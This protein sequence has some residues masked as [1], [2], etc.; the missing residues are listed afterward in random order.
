MR[1][2]LKGRKL[3]RTASHRRATLNA[4]ATAL[5]RHKKIK[6][7]LAKA[8]ET[9]VFVE[10]LITKA[11]QDTVVARRHVAR[12]IKEK[13]VLQ[14]LF[15]EVAPKVAERNG[16]YTRVVKLGRRLGD[17]AEMA[18]IE[19]VDY[20]D[21]GVKKQPKKKQ[22]EEP[23]AEAETVETVEA[24]EEEAAAAEDVKEAEV[25]EEETKAE[26]EEE[27]KEEAKAEETSEEKAEEKTEE[28]KAE[29]EEKKEEKK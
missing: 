22:K 19:L 6:T 1:H 8:K 23:V 15:N 5:I 29:A 9:R 24:T 28:P 25:V 2:R 26:A 27:V 14:E 20:N 7:T 3:S 13:E 12:F 10:P 18:I 17:A 21:T 16:G 11:K 4:L